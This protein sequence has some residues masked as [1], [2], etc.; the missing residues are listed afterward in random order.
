MR[1]TLKY[2]GLLA[3]ITHCP[4]ESLE[5]KADVTTLLGLKSA[6][7]NR[8]PAFQKTVYSIALNR[9]L[10]NDEVDLKEADVIAFLPPFAGG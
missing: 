5:L 3:E 4:E 2:F 8:F 6:I 10:C 7:E 1:V 9:S